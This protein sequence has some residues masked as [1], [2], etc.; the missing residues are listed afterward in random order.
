MDGFHP[1]TNNIHSENSFISAARLSRKSNPRRW[2]LVGG[3]ETIFVDMDLVR[4]INNNFRANI[5][6][7]FLNAYHS[8]NKAPNI[9]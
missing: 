5:G 4:K 1:E 2:M 9:M 8:I 3:N 6:K 7:L